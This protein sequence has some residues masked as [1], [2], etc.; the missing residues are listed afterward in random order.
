MKVRPEEDAI[1]IIRKVGIE[2]A[3]YKV[4]SYPRLIY[5]I[6][7]TPQ[8]V[9]ER[10]KKMQ[11]FSDSNGNNFNCFMFILQHDDGFAFLFE[12]GESDRILLLKL[13]LNTEN[14]IEKGLG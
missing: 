2:A 3:S 1:N 11:I 9:K 10:G 6:A 12:N 14:L 7:V 8:D 5:D 13:T 4:G